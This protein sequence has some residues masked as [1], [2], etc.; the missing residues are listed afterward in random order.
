MIPNNGVISQIHQGLER[1]KN[2]YDGRSAPILRTKITGVSE[3]RVSL[4]G[5]ECPAILGLIFSQTQIHKNEFQSR[6]AVV[7]T[8][9]FDKCREKLETALKVSSK[10]FLIRLIAQ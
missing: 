4:R 1:C 5:R 10:A 6:W 2:L 9:K 3:L 7:S 8:M